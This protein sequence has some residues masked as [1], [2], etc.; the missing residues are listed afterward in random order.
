MIQRYTEDSVQK[1]A[2]L[3]TDTKPVDCISGSVF[4][5]LDTTKRFIFDGYNIAWT[6]INGG[7]YAQPDLSGYATA[8]ELDELRN[9]IDS[10]EKTGVGNGI[11]LVTAPTS[12]ETEMSVVVS[13]S[14]FDA[15][16]M[17]IKETET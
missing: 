2:G 11:L 17:M 7:E 6:E 14:E 15:V 9:R 10:L 12:G 16:N 3:S 1:F 8:D 13:G 5:E 4:V